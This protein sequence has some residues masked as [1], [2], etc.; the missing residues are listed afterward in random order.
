MAT[1]TEI[2]VIDAPFQTLTTSLN[3][4]PVGLA[5]SYNETSD[6]WSFDLSVKG[7]IVITGRRIVL[8]VDLLKPFGLGLGKLVAVD[9]DGVGAE[10]GR[11]DLPAGLV[12]LLSYV[13]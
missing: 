5:L 13:G 12:R 10:P 6:R 11:S 1:V 8:G 2:P 7:E 9:W 4:T 3:G